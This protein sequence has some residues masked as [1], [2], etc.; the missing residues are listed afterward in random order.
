MKHF[1]I[2]LLS[3]LSASAAWG[4]DISISSGQL[5]NIIKSGKLQSESSLKLTGTID[6]RDLAALESLPANIKRLDLSGVTIDGL[7]TSSRE[8]FGRALFK[9]GEIPAYTFFQSKLEELVLPASVSEIGE[10]AFAASSLKS[11]QIPVG[12]EKVDNY[13]FYGCPNLTSVSLPSSIREIGKGAFGNCFALKS[14]SLAGTKITEIPERAFA[15]SLQLSQ[16]SLPASVTKIGREAFTHTA[17]ADLN[18]SAVTEFEPFALS[19]MP[20]LEHLTINPMAEIPAGLLMDDTSLISLA[21]SPDNI[22]DYFAANCS[23]LK[24]QEAISSALSIGRYA[25]ANN[26]AEILIL[27]RGLQSLDKGV[28]SGMSRLKKIDVTALD[29][30]IPAV[31]ATTFSGIDQHDIILFVTDESFQAWLDHPVWGR[32]LVNSNNYSEVE[33]IPAVTE[34]ISISLMANNI[35]ISAPEP[36]EDVRVFSTD[37][38][39]LFAARPGENTADIS[40]ESFPSG[41]VILVAA[42]SAGHSKTAS[43][44]IK[45]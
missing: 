7:V 23:S 34:E 33:N 14:I 10:G 20:Y 35:H 25:F 41:V 17:I 42:D 36:L 4:A 44:V 2:V 15:G 27:P 9:A 13:A 37:G 19:G 40:T 28:L 21:G 29:D 43:L 5:D 26:P 22:P 38:R 1:N 31:D 11:I 3:L 45:Y 24:T 12:I 32:F 30:H 6:A 18:L 16:L 8:Y 39:T